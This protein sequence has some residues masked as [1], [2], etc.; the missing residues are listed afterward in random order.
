MYDKSLLRMFEYRKLTVWWIDPKWA[1]SI[2]HHSR[3]YGENRKKTSNRSYTKLGSRLYCNFNTTYS[4]SSDTRIV[5]N[6]SAMKNSSKLLILVAIL[7]SVLAASV[8][9]ALNHDL[10]FVSRLQWMYAKADIFG[11]QLRW[12]ITHNSLIIS[13]GHNSLSW[14]CQHIMQY[15]SNFFGVMNVLEDGWW[16]IILSSQVSIDH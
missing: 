8:T 13:N 15:I 3:K 14:M 16:W 6:D 1:D 10:I 9:T 11:N 5:I 7:A 4:S 2:P 12:S